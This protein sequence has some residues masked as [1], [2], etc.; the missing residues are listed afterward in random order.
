MGGLT[1]IQ[2][3]LLYAAT[4]V[5]RLGTQGA[6]L[7]QVI[8]LVLLAFAS[9]G[10][11]LTVSTFAKSAIQA[12]TL[13][14]LLL[15]PQILLSGFTPPVEDMSPPA[16]WVGQFMPSFASER[17]ADVSFLLDRKITGDLLFDYRTPYSNLNDWYRS[18]TGETLITGK[19]YTDQRPLW[20]GY[21]SLICWTLAGLVASFLLLAQKERE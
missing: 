4:A 8:G 7:W 15:I 3:L 12:M 21:L 16:V 11:G 19:I 1:A 5:V 9:T 17:I 10:I 13:V 14:P 20:V 2:S 18:K 6:V